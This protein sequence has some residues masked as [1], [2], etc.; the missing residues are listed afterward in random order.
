MRLG[1]YPGPLQI[2]TPFAI[3]DTL[4]ASF[5]DDEASVL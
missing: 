2:E 5:R 1:A 4:Q 3:P